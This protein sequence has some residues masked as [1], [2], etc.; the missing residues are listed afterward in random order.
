MVTGLIS[1]RVCVWV[2]I[3]GD[4]LSVIPSPLSAYPASYCS[5]VN[6]PVPKVIRVTSVI[7]YN[8]GI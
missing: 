7:R 3:C 5:M 8:S 4:Y 1:M 6:F 2:H